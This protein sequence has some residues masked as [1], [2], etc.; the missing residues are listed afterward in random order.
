MVDCYIGEIRPFAGQK[1]PEDWALCDGKVLNISD[2]PALFALLGTRFGGDGAKTFALP[3]LRGRLPIGAGQ[4]AGLKNN[5][6]FAQKG[7]NESVALTDVNMPTHQH[8]FNVTT[9]AANSNSP[10]GNVYANTVL[11]VFYATTPQSG[12]VT[13]TLKADTISNSGGSGVAHE[14]RMPALAI[15]FIIALNG[16]YP[17]PN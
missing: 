7:G 5:Y 6:A 11:H 3:D 10:V 12:S 9:A 15:N 2:N 14:N 4:G 8:A 17:T 13:Q 1:A 16:I